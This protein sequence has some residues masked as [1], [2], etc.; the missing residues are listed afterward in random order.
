M[1][2]REDLIAVRKILDGEKEVFGYLVNKYINMLYDLS[3]RMLNDRIEADD[4]VQE[5]FVKALTKI[6]SFDARYNFRNW[7]YTIALNLI[8][9]KLKRK[10]IVS[11]TSLDALFEDKLQQRPPDESFVK[12][13]EE[14]SLLSNPPDAP[15]AKGGDKDDRW[16]DE[17]LVSDIMQSLDFDE[18]KLFILFYIKNLPCREISGVLKTSEGNVKVKLHRLR[19][20][21]FEKFKDKVL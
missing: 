3:L 13:E 10:K 14:R 8:K 9:N 20:R 4:I 12:S 6:S 18:R 19:K 16:R 17:G 5:T 2:E 15:F 1:S 11:F 21:I 7:I